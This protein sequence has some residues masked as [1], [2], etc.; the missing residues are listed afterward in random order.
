MMSSLRNYDK[1]VFN[2]ESRNK[3]FFIE[4]SCEDLFPLS[5]LILVKCSNLRG[6]APEKVSL[7]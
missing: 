1:F 3:F 7:G 6:I 2:H 5:L 4:Y